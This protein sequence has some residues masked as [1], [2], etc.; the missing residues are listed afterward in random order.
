M[1]PSP[2]LAAQHNQGLPSKTRLRVRYLLQPTNI[3]SSA[4]PPPPPPLPSL[5]DLQHRLPC[6]PALP[7]PRALSAD[8]ALPYPTSHAFQN[9][10]H[11][12]QNTLPHHVPLTSPQNS[13]TPTSSPSMTPTPS[14]HCMQIVTTP[15][16]SGPSFSPTPPASAPPRPPAML[17]KRE[18]R[19]MKNRISAAR[20]RQRKSDNFDSLTRELAEAKQVIHALTVQLSNR[21][22]ATVV[23]VPHDLRHVL[24][25]DFVSVDFLM[26]VLRGFVSR[27]SMPSSASIANASMPAQ[28]QQQHQQ[29]QQQQLHHMHHHLHRA[30]HG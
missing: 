24:G 4:S 14:I 8:S 29:Q 2:H 21:K 16:P 12:P 19:R 5:S 28:Q 25:H 26:D 15:T 10:I 20:S 17:D 6:P 13:L 3:A 1:T 7:P 9:H 22:E 11:A 18:L 27:S 23:A 30:A